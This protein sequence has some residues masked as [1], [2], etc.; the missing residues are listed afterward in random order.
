MSRRL[1]AIG[2]ISPDSHKLAYYCSWGRHWFTPSDAERASQGA[3][4]SHGC[5]EEHVHLLENEARGRG[6]PSTGPG[7]R[8]A[9]SE[10]SPTPNHST[11]AA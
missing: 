3:D 8:G 4:V 11:E 5:C 2:S 1:W 10:A 6:E 7:A 9:T